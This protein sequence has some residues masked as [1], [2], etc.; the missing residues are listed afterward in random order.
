MK[1]LLNKVYRYFLLKINSLTIKQANIFTTLFIFIF[2]I[3]FA[4]LLIKENYYDYER[5]LSEEM[6]TKS[7][8]LSL[9]LQHEEK[10]KKLKTLLIKNTIAIA[11]LAFILF[12]IMLGFYK[13]FNTLL[14]RDIQAFLD[15]FKGT[16]HNE[17]VLNP[18]AIFF[19]EFKTMVGYA[20]EMVDTI[21]DQK[22]SLK[23]LNIG[24]EDKVKAK[25]QDLENILDAQKEFLR[26]TVHETNTP[27][28]VIL[29]SLELYGM[30]NEKDKNLS[31][32]E[33]AAKN[34]F[35]IYDDLSYLVKKE[36]VEYPRVAVDIEKFVKS[37]I[38]FFSEVATLSKVDFKFNSQVEDIYI[39][40]NE[41][42]LQRIIDNTITNA[43][44]Y[45][46]QNEIVDIILKQSGWHVDFSVGSHS[47]PIKDVDK[48]FD[49]YYREDVKIDKNI[50]GFGI[51]LRL[52]KNIC[53]EEDVNISIS[54]DSNRN[55][56]TYTFKVMGE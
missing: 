50:Q 15:F 37:R 43:I 18:H 35:N 41:T 11:T 9:E 31:K 5:A 52:V 10:Q 34:I 51:G 30:K 24:L 13:I 33:A 46:Y 29:T 40:F 22:S 42:K 45:T 8:S 21:N 7:S 49:E 39:Y 32:V 14:Q 19:K 38:D 56:F 26:Y 28:S 44:K 36:H 20:N 2:T 48:I 3:V 47:Q 17:Q 54:S 25:T 16:A 6:L 23:E 55:V 27:L 4:Y 1:T 53:D 12:A